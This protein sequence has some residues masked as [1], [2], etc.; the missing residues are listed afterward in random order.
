MCR[1]QP[2][3]GEVASGAL[4]RADDLPCGRI[5]P[6]LAQVYAELRGDARAAWPANAISWPELEPEEGRY[7]FKD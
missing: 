2:G 6:S 3:C 5:R 4:L 1:R 7:D